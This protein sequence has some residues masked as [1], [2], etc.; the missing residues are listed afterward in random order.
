MKV[1]WVDALDLFLCPGKSM[2]RFS[3]TSLE[4]GLGPFLRV[5]AKSHAPLVSILNGCSI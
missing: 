5:E 3:L 2:V 4:M 1:V